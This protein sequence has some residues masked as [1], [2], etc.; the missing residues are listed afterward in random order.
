MGWVV[1]TDHDTIRAHVFKKS[2][3][4]VGCE[5]TILDTMLV[6]HTIHVNAFDF[7]KKQY[8]ELQAL[9]DEGDLRG[10][11]KYCTKQKIPFQLNHPYWAEKAEHFNV[12]APAKIA[13]LFPVLEINAGR[14]GPKN[15]LALHLAKRIGKGISSGSDSHI[16]KVGHV[17]TLAPGR[18]FRE[19][20]ANVAKGNAVIVRKDLS[21]AD[22]VKEIDARV[23]AVC[24]KE[25]S[26]D[27]LKPFKDKWSSGMKRVDRI[28]MTLVDLRKYW[29]GRFL[30]K[31]LTKLVSITRLGPALYIRNESKQGKQFLQEID[32]S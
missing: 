3:L 6:G 18:S 13:P 28:A 24:S 29:F 1:F 17:Y 4:I 27:Q 30:V 5:F 25:L 12:F 10:F 14:V 21:V 16:D 22:L 19:W 7:S 32:H 8:K 15:D 20:F 31:A 23:N 2:D 11:A 26:H 9:A